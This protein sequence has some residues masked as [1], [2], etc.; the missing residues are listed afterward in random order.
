MKKIPT[1]IRH[2]PWEE[3][4][5]TAKELITKILAQVIFNL[6]FFNFQKN[7][8]EYVYYAGNI[9]TIGNFFW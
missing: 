8:Y 5:M 6:Y 3:V 4:N 1:I 9:N 7:R 2:N